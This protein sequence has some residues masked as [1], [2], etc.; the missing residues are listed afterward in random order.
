MD[1]KQQ[2][3]PAVQKQHSEEIEIDLQR[4]FG[5]LMNKSWL[6]GLVAIVCA[7]AVFFGTLFFV[8]PQYQSSAMFYVNNSAFSLGEASLSISSAD[9]SASRGLV[10]TYII[11]LNTRQVLNDVIDYAG[12][13][14]TYNEVR[15]M[16]S[17]A[18]VDDTEIFQVVVTS[19]DPEEAEKIADAIAYILPKQIATIIDGSSAK[20]V[21]AAVLPTVPSSPNYTKN[22]IIGFLAGLVLMAALVILR[23]LMDTTIRT[24]EDIAQCCKQPVLASVPDMEVEIK[25]GYYSYGYDKK[26]KRSSGSGTDTKKVAMVGSEISFVAAEAYKLLRTK[27]Q[28]SFADESNC[29][30]IGI[31]SALPGEGKSLSAV[32]LA[33]SM[34][35]LGKKVLLIDG[36]MRRP[37]LPGKLTIKKSPGLS[38][39][40]A[41]QCH[42]EDVLQ[43]CGIKGSE[44]AYKVIAAGRMPPNPIELLSSARMERMLD[45]MREHYDY[46][47]LD[48]PPVG[49]VSDAMAVS[50]LTDGMLLVVRQNY[51]DRVTL[52]AATRQFEFIGT[53]LLGV[54]L[55]CTT[56][57][58]SGYGNKHYRRYYKRNSRKYD[59][60]FASEE[61]KPAAPKK[62]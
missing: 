60:R 28:F 26:R 19:P 1:E 4:L 58:G 18:D 17:A 33:Y 36:D 30:I 20:V 57:A 34:S 16:V 6:I 14:R 24:E 12:V 35:E 25:G 3:N 43:D 47:I 41:N 9:I 44:T 2:N 50:R 40:L 31:S 11:I 56:E 55:N 42:V 38:D 22:T 15:G 54:V 62:Q 46:I 48:L 29:R 32:N 52:G 51:C 49:E 59:G 21:D 27:L 13:D 5:T 45:K 10:Q 61:R 39:Y 7:V 53:K 8:T 23:D 37:S